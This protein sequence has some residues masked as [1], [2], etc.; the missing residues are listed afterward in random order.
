[1][2]A[3]A[4]QVVAEVLQR[5]QNDLDR[6]WTLEDA[7]RTSGYEVHHFAHTFR[8]V[9]GTPPLAYLRQLRL[10]RAAHQLVLDPHV[11]IGDIGK[12]AGYGS[13]EA[14][15][16]AFRRAFGMSPR[17]FRREGSSRAGGRADAPQPHALVDLTFPPGLHTEPRIEQLGPLHGWTVIAENF[18]DPLA[19]AAAF[20]PLLVACPP[21]GPWQLGGVS[22]PWGWVSG[23]GMQELRAL[24]IMPASAPAPEPPIVPWRLPR[25]WFACFDYNGEQDGIAGACAW[26]MAEWVSRSG[27]RAGF[28]P[29][30]SLVEGVLN[31][32][33]VRARLHAPIEAIG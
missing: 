7:A 15:T 14:F 12:A 5:M 24:R 31:T 17:Y 28:A 6:A 4:W 1:V 8:A 22:Q 18:D 26:I 20:L 32:S 30:F 11:A 27:L 21:D 3:A 2:S 19:I 16:R 29:L 33:P 10:E 13:L 25:G 9:V 23:S